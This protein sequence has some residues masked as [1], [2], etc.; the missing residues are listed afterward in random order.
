MATS[1]KKDPDAILDYTVDWTEWLSAI[2]DTITTSV[3]IL[4]PSVTAVSD[5]H[6]GTKATV[7][8][9]G[10]TMETSVVITNRITTVGGRT[11]DRSIT[12]KIAS[13]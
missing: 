3:W 4:D 13:R 5:S 10:G 7:F 8:I 6:T 11:D 1:F 12:L 9:S 2:A